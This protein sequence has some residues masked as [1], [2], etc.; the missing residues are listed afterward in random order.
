MKMSFP[1]LKF[2]ESP[3]CEMMFFRFRGMITRL[4]GPK[5]ESPALVAEGRKRNILKGPR[6]PKHSNWSTGSKVIACTT[7]TTQE[8]FADSCRQNFGK[9]QKWSHDQS[10][11]SCF[12]KRPS[13]LHLGKSKCSR[14]WFTNHV[15]KSFLWIGIMVVV[16]LNMKRRYEIDKRCLQSADEKNMC[17]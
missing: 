1:C 3:L 15:E 9:M 17:I 10:W 6:T 13:S 7:Q 16:S 2:H 14:S 8:D 12:Y 5:F 4:S 11:P